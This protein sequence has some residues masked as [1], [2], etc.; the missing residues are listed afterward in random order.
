MQISLRGG[1]VLVSGVL[2]CFGVSVGKAEGESA[3]KKGE[4]DRAI[5][6]KR[7]TEERTERPPQRID[8]QIDPTGEPS[9]A[10]KYRLYPSHA[11]LKPGNSVPYY[12]RSVLAV[13]GVRKE[14]R[15]EFYAVYDQ[16]G[17]TP[18]ETCRQPENAERIQRVID[19]YQAALRELDE[20]TSR[21]Q[22]DWDWQLNRLT[23]D[24]PFTYRLEETLNS[25][26]IAR[27]L[28]LRAR[29]EAAEGRFDEALRTVRQVFKL[30]RDVAQ[31]PM[32]I[33]SLVGI[34][35]TNIMARDLRDIIGE[36]GCP[37]LYWALATVP[38]PLIP[39]RN[40]MEFEAQIYEQLL[41]FLRDPEHQEHSA[42]EWARLFR[43]GHRTVAGLSNR[44]RSSDHALD[45]K[46]VAL[47]MRGYPVA[48][49][50]LIATGMDRQRVER[51]PVGQVVAIY[52]KRV[53]Q[54]IYDEYF[55]WSYI[56]YQR[57][58]SFFDRTTRRLKQTGYW[59]PA[60]TKEILPIANL[61]LP[62]VRQAALAQVRLQ[63]RIKGL[64]VLEAVRL[65]MAAN[66]GRFP[67][68]LDDID[69]VPIPI[70]PLTEEPYEYHLEGDTAV[71]VVPSHP[72]AKHVWWELHV[73]RR[74]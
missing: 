50:E 39:V 8:L 32:L 19:T 36:A 51:M 73:T 28:S 29:L 24:K 26:D 40:S 15:D 62:A 59:G 37:N 31:P 72:F 48:K 11:S 33:D 42:Q 17:N 61:A 38:D 23:G 12:Y 49:R 53:T 46:A 18:L 65:H 66:G 1:R 60:T 58:Q 35:I 71:L 34:A 55:K 5:P 21:Q 27:V 63:T 9:P 64:M 22:T 14:Q 10:L 56:D 16:F 13:T 74:N 4:I 2:L 45:A 3:P 6:S 41:P 43:E 57:G 30:G 7:Q 54:Y 70:C 44:G 68:T 25:R 67:T 47:M 52:Q 20:A 69:V